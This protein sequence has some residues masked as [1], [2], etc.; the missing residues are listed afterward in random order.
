[1]NLNY[2][3]VKCN[4]L[5]RLQYRQRLVSLYIS[6]QPALSLYST[7]T[8]VHLLPSTIPADSILSAAEAYIVCATV[9][10]GGEA[11]CS[12]V[13]KTVAFM[14]QKRPA[15]LHLL[16]P[17]ARSCRVHSHRFCMHVLSR[18]PVA[19]P[20][21]HI[22]QHVV[23]TVLVLRRESIHRANKLEPVLGSVGMGKC[24]LEYIRSVLL[25]PRQEFVAPCIHSFLLQVGGAGSGWSVGSSALSSELPLRLCRQP[26]PSPRTISLCVVPR[27]LDY[28]VF[29]PA[30]AKNIHPTAAGS[31]GTVRIQLLIPA[32]IR[33]NTI[34]TTMWPF[35]IQPI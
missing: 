13:P 17:R 1:M 34:T 16:G 19:H 18:V 12:A 25:S 27:H 2:Y 21:P 26:R 10:S 32:Q 11:R 35:R 5:C 14:A 7:A 29:A 33:Q 24:T 6:R 22:A 31:T 15:F 28:C 8:C 23:Q 20:L 4:Q 30:T 9:R 3:S